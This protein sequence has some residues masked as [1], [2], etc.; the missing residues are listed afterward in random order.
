MKKIIFCLVLVLVGLGFFSLGS[1]AQTTSDSPEITAS[2]LSPDQAVILKNGLDKL[3]AILDKI[4]QEKKQF[5]Q[6]KN[7]AVVASLATIKVSLNEINTSIQSFPVVVVQPATEETPVTEENQAKESPVTAG[8]ESYG[9]SPSVWIPGIIV[10]IA[11]IVGIWFWRKGPAKEIKKEE[12]ITAAPI[13][14][15]QNSEPIQ[16]EPTQT[17]QSSLPEN[18]SQQN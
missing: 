8:E 13:Q 6:E 16:N 2:V 4:V 1:Q 3:S 15:S 7:E 9:I 14:M 5:S 18:P 10:L 11:I 12:K 17:I